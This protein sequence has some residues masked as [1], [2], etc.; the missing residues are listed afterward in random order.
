MSCLLFC[1]EWARRTWT[2]RFKRAKEIQGV[3]A[4]LCGFIAL[5]IKERWPEMSTALAALT[6]LPFVIFAAV[7]LGTVLYGFVTAPFEIYCEEAVKVESAR[8][9][10]AEMTEASEPKLKFI[11]A[12]A[13]LDIQNQPPEGIRRH[14][15]A[16]TNGSNT[17]RLDHV[18]VTALSWTNLETGESK[19][20]HAKLSDLSGAT[21]VPLNPG[22][23]AYFNAASVRM[24]KTPPHMYLAPPGGGLGQE[25]VS[26]GKYE[27]EIEAT[28]NLTKPLLQRY[29]L[30]LTNSGSSTLRLA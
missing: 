4:L 6:W 24:M 11:P 16:L 28:S 20:V 29:I 5:L 27:L 19:A 13:G 18:T 30:E 2:G 21:E 15:L 14:R 10:I 17:E 8:A 25:R 1:K 12:A 9:Q 7:F 26:A 23:T 3:G 22:G